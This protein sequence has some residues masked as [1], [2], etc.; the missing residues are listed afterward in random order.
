M[1]RRRRSM[2]AVEQIELR[3]RAIDEI[4]AHPEWTLR[5]AIRHLKRNLL[6]TSDELA[7][8]AQV[9]VRT[10]RDIEQG[11]SLGTVQTVNRILGV[12]GLKLGVVRRP[13]ED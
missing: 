11:R 12:V 10:V 8:L 9:S 7:R 1:D 2:S 13:R 3:Q 5:E 6:V 4:L